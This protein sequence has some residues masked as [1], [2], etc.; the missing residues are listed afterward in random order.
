MRSFLLLFLACTPTGTLP[1]T[2]FTSNC[3]LQFKGNFP[4]NSPNQFV[5]KELL[6]RAEFVVI[7]QFY[8]D[9]INDPHFKTFEQMCASL[10]GYTVW[11]SLDVK[12]QQPSGRWVYGETACWFAT[13]QFGGT[14]PLGEGSFSHELA[15]AIQRCD[16]PL[17]MDDPKSPDHPNWH[18]AGIYDSL[19]RANTRIVYGDSP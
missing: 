4:F 17:P 5:T 19:A 12:W 2:L 18:R 8:R 6:D 14:V 10:E 13:M 16:A 9:N 11:A 1:E 15:H 3:G 7:D